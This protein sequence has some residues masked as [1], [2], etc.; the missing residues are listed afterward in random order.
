MMNLKIFM[1]NERSQT[2]KNYCIMHKRRKVWD[3]E[4][5]KNQK[6]QEETLEVNGSMNYD[7]FQG[8]RFTV[9]IEVIVSMD[10]YMCQDLAKTYFKCTQF[11]VC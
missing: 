3:R 6:R 7:H 10:V 1:L 4:G 11:I 8:M 9:L 2:K 5:M